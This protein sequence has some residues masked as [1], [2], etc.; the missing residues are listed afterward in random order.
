VVPEQGSAAGQP[1]RAVRLFG[2]SVTLPPGLAASS[3]SLRSLA[4]IAAGAIV[5][6]VALFGV[7]P[8]IASAQISAAEQVMA[9]TVSHK[10]TVDAGFT[11][12]FASGP[13]S[14]DLTAAKAEMA[15][16]FQAVDDALALVQTDEHDLSSIDQTLGILQVIALPSHGAIDAERQRINAALS[17]LAQA[18][19][20]LT[21]GSEEGKVMAPYV[22]A[23]IGLNKMN[24]ALNKRD[25][26][27]AAAAYPD[28]QRS[29]Q[30]AIDL[31][32]APGLPAGTLEQLHALNNF[33]Q[34]YQN[35]IQAAQ[36]K[37]TAAMKADLASIQTQGKAFQALSNAVPSD[38]DL[39]TFGPNLKA[40]D[41]SIKGLSS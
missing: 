38:W 32:Q 3:K 13:G 37:D 19:S 16:H 8:A 20:A 4:Y 9:T 31:A 17:G 25:L 35:F 40:Y 26:G 2:R 14:K 21:V 15:K 11:N 33:L 27:G 12:L 39:K 30:Q 23:L 1:S 18:D 6:A 24:A 41:A 7:L 34:T 10:P 28:A 5:L 22:D 36:N 29:L